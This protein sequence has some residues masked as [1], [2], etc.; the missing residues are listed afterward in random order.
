MKVIGERNSSA[1]L[2][3]SYPTHCSTHDK[4]GLS[5]PKPKEKAS[6]CSGWAEMPHSYWFPNW[7]DIAKNVMTSL[8][9]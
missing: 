3:I 1:Q 4:H 8:L 9:V 7:L 6:S 5:I 2:T